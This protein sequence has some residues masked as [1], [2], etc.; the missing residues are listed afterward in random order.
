MYITSL[1]TTTEVYVTYLH[2]TTISSSASKPKSHRSFPK[3]QT[4]KKKKKKKGKHKLNMIKANTFFEHL[5][6]LQASKMSWSVI[7]WI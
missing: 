1:H 4:Q 5:S 3:T 7:T 6:C 2:T